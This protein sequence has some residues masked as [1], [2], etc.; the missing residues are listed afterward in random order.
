MTSVGKAFRQLSRPRASLLGPA[1][2][3]RRAQSCCHSRESG[4]P[5]HRDLLPVGGGKLPFFA[6]GPPTE[7]S[8]EQL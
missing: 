6:M 4:G 8:N 7:M 2:I 5:T 3:S 1:K